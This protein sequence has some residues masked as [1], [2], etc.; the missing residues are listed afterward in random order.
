MTIVAAQVRTPRADRYLAQLSDHLGNM[1]SGFL[2]RLHRR[3]HHG[4]AHGSTVVLGVE[5]G[6]D[7]ARIEFDWGSCVLTASAD[8]LTVQVQADDLAALTRGQDLIG[9]RLQ[10]I[11]RREGLTVEWGPPAAG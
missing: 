9:H 10:T 3:P 4:S 6:E 2:D 7:R 8:G 1:R 5:R 11:G